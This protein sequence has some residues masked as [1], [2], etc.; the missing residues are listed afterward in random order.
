M[1]IVALCGFA[2]EPKGTVRARAFPMLQ[3]L[4]RRGHQVTL[5]TIPYD[6][7]KL[8]GAEFV[9][10]GVPVRAIPL[11]AG[12]SKRIELPFRAVREIALLKP[13][14]V[15]IFKPKGYAG[16]AAWLLIRQG[17]PAGLDRL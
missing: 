10:E 7:P 2:W 3:E 15:H 4:A 8:S 11:D 14:V 1:R 16:A 13:D 12:F 17:N 6:N 5:L 9:Q